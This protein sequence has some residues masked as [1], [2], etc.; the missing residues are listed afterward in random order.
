MLTVRW[1]VMGTRWTESD[2]SHLIDAPFFPIFE[3]FPD[4]GKFSLI[5]P[6]WLSQKQKIF[7]KAIL[8]MSSFIKRRSKP[9]WF[10]E[11]L[12]L[13]TLLASLV[14]IWHPLLS[15]RLGPLVYIVLSSFYYWP[16]KPMFLWL[17]P[18]QCQLQQGLEWGWVSSLFLL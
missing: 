17:L 3:V 16:W 8:N 10:A 9:P 11:P 2:T 7:L 5:M 1:S 18:Q 14:W 12:L 4:H 13:K 6:D 15:L